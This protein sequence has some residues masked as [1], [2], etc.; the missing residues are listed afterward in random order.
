MTEMFVQH[1]TKLFTEEDSFKRLFYVFCELPFYLYSNFD[2]TVSQ[3]IFRNP[4]I[5]DYDP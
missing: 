5:Q 1:D 2:E 4:D 3:S